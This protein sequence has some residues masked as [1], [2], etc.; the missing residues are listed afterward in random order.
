MYANW[1]VAGEGTINVIASTRDGP[2]ALVVRCRE[3]QV[4]LFVD[5]D[6]VV[7]YS[8]EIAIE[9]QFDDGPRHRAGWGLSTEHDST[10]APESRT[11]EMLRLIRQS[12]ELSVWVF[13][14]GVG[15]IQAT[16]NV[17]GFD[18]EAEPLL[19]AWRLA[20]SPAPSRRVEG[21]GCFLIPT[22]FLTVLGAIAIIGVG[23]G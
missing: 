14:V 19:R 8:N 12:E 22:A 23:M 4:D 21:G 2:F 9:W 1:R 3:G 20:G 17:A 7:T 16:F 5:W 13:P 15:P 11:V 18:E 6:M 10:Y